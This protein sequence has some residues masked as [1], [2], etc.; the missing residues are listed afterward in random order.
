MRRENDIPLY[1]LETRHAAV[2]RLRH[3]GF[4][5]P[6]EQLYTNVLTMLDLAGNSPCAL[7]NR[8]AGASA[9]HRG[10]LRLLQPGTYERLLRRH[11]HRRGGRGDL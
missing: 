6:Y 9:G 4:S 3:L 5:L 2:R 10:R 7:P 8:T 1:S 11:D